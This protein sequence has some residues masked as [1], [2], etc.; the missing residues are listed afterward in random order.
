VLLADF[1]SLCLGFKL[2]GGQFGWG[3]TDFG[4]RMGFFFLGVGVMNF[5]LD[6]FRFLSF[7]LLSNCGLLVL[8]H[9]DS[10]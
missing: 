9:L 2:G 8:D 7:K 6:N 5:F 4:G 10:V 1:D 3:V